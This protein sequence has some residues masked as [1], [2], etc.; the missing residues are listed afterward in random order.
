M[1]EE[2][3]QIFSRACIRCHGPKKQ[4]SDFRMDS[5]AALNSG[6]EISEYL[7]VSVMA[8]DD[9]ESSLLLKFILAEEESLEEEIFPMPPDEKDRLSQDEIDVIR[10][11]LAD[12]AP[13]A[14]S[15]VL[16]DTYTK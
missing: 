7:E 14:E 12:G 8:P 13:W 6:G 9:P 16:Q 10:A 15:Q 1:P 4:K 3:A 5:K 11:W 2:V